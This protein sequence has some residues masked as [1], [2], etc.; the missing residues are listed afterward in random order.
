MMMFAATVL[1]GAA[2]AEDEKQEQGP[3]RLELNLVDGSRIIGVPG[4]ETVPVE[5][6]YAKM[7]IP[8]KQIMTIRI[9]EDHETV[10]FDLQNGDKIKGVINLKPIKL[11]T[12]FGQVSIGTE[13]IKQL[14]V[15]MSGGTGQKGLVLWNRLGSE[16]D[17]KN[18]RVGPGGKLNAG[19]FVPGR[20]G[21]GLELNMQE[22]FGVTFPPDLLATPAGCIEFWCKISNFP[23]SLPGGA[24]PGLIGWGSSEK[25]EGEVLFFAANDG[26]ANGGIC[27]RANMAW[28]GTG[29]FGSWTYSNAI[30]GGNIAEWH[31]YAVV[32]NTAG[33]PGIEDGARKAAVFVDGK[34]NSSHGIF[35]NA[36]H[37]LD[38][39]K[40]SRIGLL[41]HHALASGT[42]AFD[43]IKIWNYAKT[44]FSDRTEE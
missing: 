2:W 41:K 18:S 34:L 43:N 20:F 26:N 6:S 37:F 33:I 8:L 44:N 9:G 27:L 42:V 19:R 14:D 4:I 15:V 11:T 24:A 40:G 36:P 30:G 5:T 3:L 16:S 7:D 35:G 29:N 21:Q 31:H 17:V 13:H 25:I 22:Q 28:I 1:A 23:T 10:S 32:W 38:L 12:V 39:P